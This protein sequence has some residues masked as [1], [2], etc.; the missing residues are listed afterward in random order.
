MES[1]FK[2]K[3]QPAWIIFVDI[4]LAP[5]AYA[6]LNSLLNPKSDLSLIFTVISLVLVSAYIIPLNIK[7][8]T[9]APAMI[10]TSDCL[11]DNLSNRSIN[12]NNISEIKIIEGSYKSFDKLV[13]NLKHP[14]DYF[15]TPVKRLLYRLKQ[16]FTANDIGI[17]VNL[18]AGSNED[19]LS[20]IHA[21]WD[22]SAGL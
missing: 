19:I 6:L 22:K 5:L 17:M 13:I 11:I 12:W 10:L 4:I 14:G 3:I 7:I 21:Y 15:N 16:L 18:I 2:F 8:I 20:G 9:G 1:N